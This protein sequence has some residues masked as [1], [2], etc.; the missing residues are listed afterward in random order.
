MVDYISKNFYLVAGEGK[1]DDKTEEVH[2]DMA[3]NSTPSTA[4]TVPAGVVY[5]RLLIVVTPVDVVAN[6]VVEHCA[7]LSPQELFPL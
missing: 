1:H 6:A 5:P 7:S 2:V 3:G 4:F